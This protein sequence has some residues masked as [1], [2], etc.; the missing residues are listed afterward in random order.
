MPTP[1]GS[2]IAFPEL[3]SGELKM[4]GN[5]KNNVHKSLVS[6]SYWS[7][8]NQTQVDL[9]KHC[10][11]TLNVVVNTSSMLWNALAIVSLPHVLTIIEYSDNVQCPKPVTPLKYQKY[12]R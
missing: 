1:G 9:P 7:H 11:S 2:T 4:A 8:G 6:L 12:S 3:C 5:M 10:W